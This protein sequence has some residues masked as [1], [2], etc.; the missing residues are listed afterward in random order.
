MQVSRRIKTL[1]GE[2]TSDDGVAD[3]GWSVWYRANEM[4]AAGQDVTLLCIGD[5]DLPTPDVVIDATREALAK[6]QT[7][8]AA[9]NGT[10]ALRDAIASRVSARSGIPTSPENVFVSNGGQGAL[11]SC[12]MAVTDP[13]DEVTIIDPYYA[14]YVPTVHAAS[15]KLNVISARPEDGFQP[16]PSA[17]MAATASSRALLMNTPN[18]PTGAVYSAAC[19]EGIAAAAQAHDMWVISDEVYDTQVH[20]GT[21]ISPRQV[22]GLTDRTLVVGSMS[23]SHVMTGFRVGWAVGPQEVIAPMTDLA[24]AL[25]YGVSSFVQAGA[26]AGL[27]GGDAAEAEATAVYTRRRNLALSQL[28]GSNVLGI[29]PPDGAMYVMLDVRRTGLSGYDFAH[30]LIETEKI[31]VM[32]GESFG[33]AAAGHIRVALTVPDDVLTEALGRLHSFAANISA[34]MDAV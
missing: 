5:H 33:T 17:V 27:Q 8:Y 19:L 7:R 16:A 23:K 15:C 10:A 13:G 34:P 9:V 30:R 28:Q 12:L 24:N 21:H 20:Q 3:D 18:N 32:P 4:I 26:L 11:Y 22:D 1:N 2:A 31:A 6:R 14:T 25:T 29:S